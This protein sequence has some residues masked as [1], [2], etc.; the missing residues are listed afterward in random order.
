ML[1]RSETNE[2]FPLT[3][4]GYKHYGYGGVFEGN[5]NI[6]KERLEGY[7][8][9][10]GVIWSPDSKKLLTY[11]IDER[12][13]KELHLIQNVTSDGSMRPVHYAYKY[14][15]PEDDVVAKAEIFLCDVETKASDM[16]LGDI[17]IDLS[18]P[19]NGGFKIASF[20]DEGN[21]ASIFRV[22]RGHQNAEVFILDINTK[23]VKHLFTESTDTFLFFD[24]YRSKFGYDPRFDKNAQK[25]VWFSEEKNRF[26]WF[27]D[28]DGH[29]HIYDYD[30]KNGSLRKQITSGEYNIRQILR[31]DD[32][33][34][35][36]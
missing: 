8:R 27:S 31:I 36:M 23:E 13:V 16:V 7:V 25:Q 6:I 2:T 24:F 30:V 20:S 33:K 1:F 34:N 3:V 18:E 35:V 4:D 9:P 12:D 5:E 11:R 32:E 29:F 22:D 28:R 15:L 10:A 17:Y 19:F 26:L 21:F 14:A